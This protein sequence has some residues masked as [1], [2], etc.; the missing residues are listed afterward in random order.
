MQPFKL[1]DNALE[2]SIAPDQRVAV[3]EARL[4]LTGFGKLGIS[5]IEG[6]VQGEAL[7]LLLF[8]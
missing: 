2:G 8:A 5:E 1:L 6:E 3:G 4:G 7:L